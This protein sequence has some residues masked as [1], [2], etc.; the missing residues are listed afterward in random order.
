MNKLRFF[1]FLILIS[2]FAFSVT[3]FADEDIKLFVNGKQLITDVAPVAVDG[4]T[5]VPVRSI[6]E[7]L[8]AEVTWIN[9][10]K[11]IIV[12]TASKRI[13]LTLDK[14]KAYVN[15]ESAV[16]DTPPMVINGR[17]LIPVR[18][19]SEKLGYRVDWDDKD[20]AVHINSNSQTPVIQ[21]ITS[22]KSGKSYI[23]SIKVKNFE[24]PEISYATNPQRF[25]ADF[26]D[27]TLSKG[28]TK[29]RLANNTIT[30]IRSAEHDDYSRVV[31]ESP[32]VVSYKVSYSG[33]TMKITITST[34]TSSDDKATDKDKDKEDKTDK[35]D[36]ETEEKEEV[37][38]KP[39][40]YVDD[41][42]VII[43]AGHGGWDSGAIGYDE[44]GSEVVFESE[45]NL[46][47]AEY[48][49]EYLRRN[50]VTVYMTRQRDKALGDTEMEDLLE[51]SEI[52]NDKEATLFVSIHNNSFADSEATGTEVLY[53]DTD[54]KLNY[55]IKSKDLA[56]NILK[57]LVKATGLNDRGVKDSPKMV[58]LNRT[59]M[60]AVIVEC[61]FVSNPDDRQLLLD[62]DSM[63][64]IGYAIGE[65][66]V[67]TIKQLP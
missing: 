59:D 22:K 65:G 32:G 44:D 60:P 19:V 51:R 8:G 66:I 62:E 7:K 45:A 49:Y 10:S 43:D 31:I 11:Q 12:K 6:F 9:S 28:D 18:F 33:D 34:D 48:V 27:A 16:M 30:E 57:P 36:E 53:A 4:R 35:K 42:I 40:I 20:R 56:K 37:K 29:D 13:V 15:N 41:P 52:A 67:N 3:A 25:I 38:E 17:T 58:V 63:Q 24:K 39:L 1:L 23:V 50:K 64:D 26:Y 2:V 54:N 61:A 47:I 46:T 14:T 21:S 5:M 55:G